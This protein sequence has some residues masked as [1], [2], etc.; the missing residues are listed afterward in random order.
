MESCRI[1]KKVQLVTL[2]RVTR[3]NNLDYQIAKE[4]KMN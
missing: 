1:G 4:Q 2:L 3:Q